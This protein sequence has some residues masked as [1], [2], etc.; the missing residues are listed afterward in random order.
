MI[1]IEQRGKLLATKAALQADFETAKLRAFKKTNTIATKVRDL[2]GNV[3]DEHLLK[4]AQLLHDHTRD[5]KR[6]LSKF[7]NK[8]DEHT[9]R[10]IRKAANQNANQNATTG[11]QTVIEISDGTYD[12]ASATDANNAAT[13][14]TGNAANTN[15]H[16]AGQPATNAST[17]GQGGRRRRGSGRTDNNRNV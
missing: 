1:S 11:Q 13:H 15:V 14:N 9:S 8:M 7:F 6:K 16:G 17:G 4:G 2:L 10:Q 12:A 5:L 3:E